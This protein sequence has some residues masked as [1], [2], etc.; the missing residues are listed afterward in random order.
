MYDGKSFFTVYDFVKAH[1]NF[2]DPEWD[3]DPLPPK[4]PKDQDP[5]DICNEQPCVCL[6]EVSGFNPCNCDN[7]TNDELCS[8]CDASP[9]ECPV[10]D[11]ICAECGDTPCSCDDDGEGKPRPDKIFITLTDGKVRQ[12][13]HMKSVLFR[14]LTV[15]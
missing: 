6:C 11:E 4:D 8:E 9:C 14:G 7:G 12:I 3:G 5:C 10:V 2:A 13:Q 15:T 1:H